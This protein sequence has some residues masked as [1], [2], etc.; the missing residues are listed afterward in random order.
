MY[1]KIALG[2]VKKSLRDFSIYFLTLAVGVAL[3]YA[4]NSITQ[5]S[6]VLELTEDARSIV[7]LLSKT[8]TGVSILLAVILGFLVV[9][10]N[11]FLIRRRKKEKCCTN[12][13]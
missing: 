6:M 1:S 9:Y 8:I 3:F 12:R 4:F 2:N 5:Q 13:N 11:Q 7:Q 10:A